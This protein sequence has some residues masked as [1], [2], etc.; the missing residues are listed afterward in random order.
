MKQRKETAAEDATK[1][2]A[3]AEAAEKEAA[4]KAEREKGAT[5]AVDAERK[6]RQHVKASS[7]S[8]LS[9]YP[10]RQGFGSAPRTHLRVCV[11]QLLRSQWHK[12]W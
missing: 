11:Y 2:K 3:A 8:W 1:A 9:Y 7:L 4:E 5:A 10:D 12:Q 6:A